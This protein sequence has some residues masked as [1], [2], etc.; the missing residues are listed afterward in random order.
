MAYINVDNGTKEYVLQQVDYVQFI[1]GVKENVT[2]I[3]CV[4]HIS[5]R[6][7]E[8]MYK[9][10]PVKNTHVDHQLKDKSFE[11]HSISIHMSFQTISAKF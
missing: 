10:E 2:A 9:A 11:V 7:I 4:F 6:S 3:A 8:L 1:R 5:D